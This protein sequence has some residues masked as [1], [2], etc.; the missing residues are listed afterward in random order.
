MVRCGVLPRQ[1]SIGSANPVPQQAKDEPA[2][3]ERGNEEEENKTP[4]DFHKG[5][6]EV[7]Q[8]GNVFAVLDVPIFNVAAAIFGH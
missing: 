7:S 6:P 2:E 8:E 5:G 4:P 3:G 1:V